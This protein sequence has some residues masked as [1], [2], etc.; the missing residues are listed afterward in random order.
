MSALL[1]HEDGPKI[2]NH[3]LLAEME[4]FLNFLKH[5]P[6]KYHSNE[7]QKLLE[8]FKKTELNYDEIM[9]KIYNA[10]TSRK[11]GLIS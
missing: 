10:A 11:D 8:D 3:N 7:C 4:T 6:F 1:T 9:H 2:T 5:L